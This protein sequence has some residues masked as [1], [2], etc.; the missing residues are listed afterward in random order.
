MTLPGLPENP[1]L[2]HGGATSDLSWSAAAFNAWWFLRLFVA[3]VEALVG[4]V[5]AHPWLLAALAAGA[6]AWRWAPHPW[7]RLSTASVIGLLVVLPDE[8]WVA[9][10]AAGNAVVTG[11]VGWAW[12]RIGRPA[13]PAGRE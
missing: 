5:V 9:G 6:L 1:P 8:P 4:D 7:W 10:A 3:C 13:L 11:L 2:W 12:L